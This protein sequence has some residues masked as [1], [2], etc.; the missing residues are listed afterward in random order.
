M[1][2]AADGGE[3]ARIARLFGPLAADVPE[4]LGLL[5]DAAVLRPREGCEQVLSV[6]AIV[7]GVHV[8]ADD[9]PA[10]MAE[11]L[12]R[13]AVSDLAAKAAEPDGA[14]LTIAWPEMFSEAARADFAAGF[15][16]ALNA[17]GLR[18]FGGDTVATSGPLT[19]S[20]TVIG[21]APLGRTVKRSEG[22]AGDRLYASGTVGD[23]VLGLGLKRGELW[24]A[25]AGDESYLLGR[26]YHPTPR[27]ELREILRTY[28][29]AAADISDG[30]L[31]DASHIAEASGTGLAIGLERLPLSFAASAWL[32]QQVEPDRAL[33]RL[34]T[35]GDDYE[36]VFALPPECAPLAEAAA[37]TAGTPITHIGE[38]T[39]APGLKVFNKGR[40]MDIDRTGYQHR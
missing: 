30:L 1:T 32:A 33:L 5:D 26:F 37:R 3:F 35:G 13:S 34:A 22:R 12:V 40:R 31:A 27:L 15:G 36:I 23:A 28:A 24:S 17:C 19:A 8:F 4:A 38:L 25:A 39:E 18:L 14:L 16:R 6:D 20:L 2:D 9:A 10:L 29:S 21:W 11:R 7:A